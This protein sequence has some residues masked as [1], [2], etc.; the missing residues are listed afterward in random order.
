MNTK[1]K[2]LIGLMGVCLLGTVGSALAF[3]RVGASATGRPGAFD[4]AVYLY[5]GSGQSS[6]TLNNVENLQQGVAQ[7]RYLEVS[8]KTTKSVAGNVQLSFTLAAADN[9]HHIKGLT[10]SV[11]RTEAL[12]NDETVEEGIDGLTAAPVLQEGSLTGN[13]N[14]AITANATAHE[15]KAYFAIAI[16]W[17]GANNPENLDAEMAGNVTI[18]QSFVAA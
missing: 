17:S 2:V 9:D 14:I 6:V 18:S 5:W 15:T 11:Y 8:P 13:V 7:Y 16:E 10:V 3:S 4:Q 12:L 1:S